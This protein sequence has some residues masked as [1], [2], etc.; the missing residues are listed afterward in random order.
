MSAGV[1]SWSML[2]AGGRAPDLDHL[3][4]L[5]TLSEDGREPFLHALLD[6]FHRRRK[7]VGDA[8]AFRLDEHLLRARLGAGAIAAERLRQA[9]DAAREED[10]KSTRL[11]SSHGYI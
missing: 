8:H 5:R 4:G 11:N 9:A 10:R 7:H 6:V 2:A 1:T 3:V